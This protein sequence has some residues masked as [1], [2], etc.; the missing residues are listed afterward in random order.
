MVEEKEKK[1][2]KTRKIETMCAQDEDLG[3]CK[4]RKKKTRKRKKMPGG[5]GAK[6]GARGSIKSS[7]LWL[8]IVAVYWKYTI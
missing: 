1:I 4:I 2:G 5:M 8:Y 3:R 7:I 6:G